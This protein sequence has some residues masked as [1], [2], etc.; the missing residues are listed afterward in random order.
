MVRRETEEAEATHRGGDEGVAP[1]G[2]TQGGEQKGQDDRRREA[3]A[4]G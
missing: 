1:T 3:G 4:D 2:A